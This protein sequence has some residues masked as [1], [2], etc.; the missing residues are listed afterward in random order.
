MKVGDLVTDNRDHI[1]EDNWFRDASLRVGL[2]LEW[3]DTPKGMVTVAWWKHGELYE[4]NPCH[5]SK[6]EVLNESR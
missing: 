1:P 6:L 2:I 4:T 3:Y 5:V